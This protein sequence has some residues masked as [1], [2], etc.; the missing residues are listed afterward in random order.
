[1]HN[2][3][4]SSSFRRRLLVGLKIRAMNFIIGTGCVA[5]NYVAR[6]PFAYAQG[7]LSFREEPE[8]LSSDIP[9]PN[10]IDTRAK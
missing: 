10:A 6:A 8:G 7:K 2:K 9:I 1:M 3:K 5:T 4:P